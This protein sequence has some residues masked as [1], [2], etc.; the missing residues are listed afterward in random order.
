M[1]TQ[2]SRGV[3]EG[4]I[5]ANQR[6]WIAENMEKRSGREAD[7]YWMFDI[8][9]QKDYWTW[10]LRKTAE[11]RWRWVG[12]NHCQKKIR[13]NFY[14]LLFFLYGIPGICP[15]FLLPIMEMA[16]GSLIPWSFVNLFFYYFLFLLVWKR[17]WFASL[18]KKEDS[19]PWLHH[20]WDKS[21][22]NLTPDSPN[23]S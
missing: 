15:F 23:T 7:S 14:R 6:R 10:H 22:F 3:L 5:L 13:G 11:Q 21:S 2:R 20:A 18:I 19:Y 4:E 17:T 16:F 12:K 1:L 8:K 9:A